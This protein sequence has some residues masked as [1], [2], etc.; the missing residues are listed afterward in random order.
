MLGGSH[1]APTGEGDGD[2]FASRHVGC[3]RDI[4]DRFA[5]WRLFHL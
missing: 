1:A 4:A 5:L 2:G 3:S